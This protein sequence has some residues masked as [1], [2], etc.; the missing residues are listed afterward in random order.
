MNDIQ[1][2]QLLVLPIIVIGTILLISVVT[3]ARW[4]ND[5]YNECKPWSLTLTLITM[6]LYIITVGV[7]G[8]MIS[9][10]S[11]DRGM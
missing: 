4:F 8:D 5:W 6:G 2:T 7:V 11:D 3:D 1:K 10:P 9:N